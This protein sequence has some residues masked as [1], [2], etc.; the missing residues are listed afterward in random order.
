MESAVASFQ[1]E[2]VVAQISNRLWFKPKQLFPFLFLRQ[3]GSY[4]VNPVELG[5]T[6]HKNYNNF[7]LKKGFSH[8]IHW[9]SLG[10][11]MT[12]CVLENWGIM[13]FEMPAYILCSRRLLGTTLNKLRMFLLV[14]GGYQNLLVLVGSIFH[15]M[16]YRRF[17]FHFKFL[18]KSCIEIRYQYFEKLDH[19]SQC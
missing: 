5:F 10:G 2:K 6:L 3:E 4:K 7:F 1:S 17:W 16:D 9:V 13:F 12:T 11:K 18:F 19:F 14:L 8:D 15:K